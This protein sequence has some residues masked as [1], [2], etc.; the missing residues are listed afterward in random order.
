MTVPQD[1][2]D[3]LILQ[4]REHSDMG[5]QRL[6]NL[7]AWFIRAHG[8][9][10]GGTSIE[11]GTRRGGSA[12]LCLKLLQHLYPPSAQPML[13]TVDPYGDK[14]YQGGDFT[15]YAAYGDHDYLMAKR[16]LREFANHAHF[17]LAGETFFRALHGQTF[18][19]RG[20]PRKFNEGCSF[21]LLDGDHDARTVLAEV[22]RARSWLAP[23]GIIFVDDIDKDPTLDQQIRQ[24]VVTAAS[25][26]ETQHPSQV[27]IEA[28]A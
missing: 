9:A 27:V 2:I 18:W 23:G 1:V 13:F 12:W 22:V 25:L 7:A 28:H 4:A 14:P 5:D 21:V 20:R 6:R 26:H 17:H 10:K 15:V 8:Q 3:S 19:W 24:P 16:L 11:I